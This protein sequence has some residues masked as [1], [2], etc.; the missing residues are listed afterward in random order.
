MEK[1]KIQ[2]GD[3]QKPGLIWLMTSSFYRGTKKGDTIPALPC[4]GSRTRALI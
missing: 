3:G 1:P 2:S 4:P